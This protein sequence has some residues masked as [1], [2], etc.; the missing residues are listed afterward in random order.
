MYNHFIDVVVDIALLMIK[1][2]KKCITKVEKTNRNN[3]EISLKKIVGRDKSDMKKP[4]T[5]TL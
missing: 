5:I 4:R 1:I 3:R 2:L